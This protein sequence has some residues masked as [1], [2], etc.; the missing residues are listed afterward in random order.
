[1]H[2][3]RL[4]VI[5]RHALVG[6]LV[7]N[8]CDLVQPFSWK[9][10]YFLLWGSKANRTRRDEVVQLQSHSSVILNLCSSDC[11]CI[12]FNVAHLACLNWRISINTFD[13]LYRTLIINSRG[14]PKSTIVKCII[15]QHI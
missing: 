2:L 8:R 4:D 14:R 12:D 13:N 11:L 6:Y 5:K 10:I 7:K 15:R 1:M 3:R 9:S